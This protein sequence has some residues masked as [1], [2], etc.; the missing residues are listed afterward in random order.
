MLTMHGGIID[1]ILFHP[2]QTDDRPKEQRGSK[3]NRTS[4]P[5]K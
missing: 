5:L 3:D 2:N 4:V 1:I